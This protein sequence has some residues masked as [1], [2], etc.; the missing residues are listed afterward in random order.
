MCR[1]R[2]TSEGYTGEGERL[3]HFSGL[4]TVSLLCALMIDILQVEPSRRL[5]S[6]AT[7]A[8]AIALALR[9]QALLQATARPVG[10]RID[11]DNDN[12][13]LVE[14]L[15]SAEARAREDACSCFEPG[16]ILSPDRAL[17]QVRI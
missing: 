6:A 5:R 15:C 10:E 3:L 13:L 4:N 12:G 2:G 17:E 9:Q 11:D 14:E 1:A 16:I 7:R 8:S